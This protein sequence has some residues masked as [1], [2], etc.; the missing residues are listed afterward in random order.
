MNWK[1]ELEKCYGEGYGDV[2]AF[3]YTCKFLNIP[4]KKDRKMVNLGDVVTDLQIKTVQDISDYGQV[5]ILKSRKEG[6]STIT[7]AWNFRH[8]WLIENYEVLLMA[9]DMTSTKY[10]KSIYQMF[11]DGI[12]KELMDEAGYRLSA[13]DYEMKYYRERDDK[14]VLWSKLRA[15]TA[16]SDSARGSTPNAI[17]FSEFAQY[18]DIDRTLKAAAQAATDDCEMVY[19]TTANG[20]NQAYDTW[21][22]ENNGIHKLFISWTD[23]PNCRM[24]RTTVKIP[25]EIEEIGRELSLDKASLNWAADRFHRRCGSNW[26]AFSQEYPW[27]PEVA[28]VSSGTRFFAPLYFSRPEPFDGH[29][30][31]EE[32]K[33]G[34]VY[35]MGVDA[36]SGSP[37]G[38]YSAFVVLKVSDPLNP[39]IVYTYRQRIETPRFANEIYRVA[40]EYRPLVVPEVNGHGLDLIHRLQE[41]NYPHLYKRPTAFDRNGEATSK[42]V[43]W[44]TTDKRGGGGPRTIMLSRLLSHV[45]GGE[46]FGQRLKP[47]DMSVCERLKSEANTLVYTVSGK[48]EH[49]TG[50]HDDTI[51]SL[52]MALMGMDQVHEVEE[53]EV[54]RRPTSIAEMLLFE[55]KGKLM[56][57]LPEGYWD[58]DDEYFREPREEDLFPTIDKSLLDLTLSRHT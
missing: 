49:D 40:N 23:S 58:E 36:A 51:M 4:S 33:P 50:C 29:H 28:F 11:H 32:Y 56:E 20:M 55:Q 37:N 24:K 12:P 15:V 41:L 17:H 8:L 57:E 25:A 3:L 43:G 34:E 39:K 7:A 19:E 2:D 1:Y 13:S 53:N 44:L 35:T 9:L 6:I 10:L 52:A 46:Y 21:Y 30:K 27:K 18:R 48:V 54:R 5:Y 38:D 26:A 31:I 14:T 45:R 16:S 47:L 42:A 22:N